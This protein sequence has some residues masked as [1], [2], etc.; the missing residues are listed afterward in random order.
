MHIIRKFLFQRRQEAAGASAESHRELEVRCGCTVVGF[1]RGWVNPPKSLNPVL[2]LCKQSLSLSFPYFWN[3]TSKGS[4]SISHTLV[5]WCGCSRMQIPQ[6]YQ[7]SSVLRGRVMC[8]V[9]EQAR[10]IMEGRGSEVV[11]RHPKAIPVSVE[12]ESM[13]MRFNATS[14]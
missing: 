1:Y 3:N 12:Q 2:T 4:L 11:R 5:R 6:D 8:G 13:R 14:E 10:G 9:V 7:G